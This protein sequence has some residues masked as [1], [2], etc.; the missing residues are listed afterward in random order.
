M[1]QLLDGDP[2]QNIGNWQW[3]ASTGADAM[4]AFRIFNPVAQGQ[5]FDPRGAYVRRFIPEL[6]PV[7]DTHVHAPW[8]AGG[9]PG[10]PPPIVEH[11]AARRRALAALTRRP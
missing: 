9:A 5:R 8:E 1:A 11:Q 2:A 3:V 4:P 6:A 7:P 10:Y